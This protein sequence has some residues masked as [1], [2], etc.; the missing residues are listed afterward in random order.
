MG[1]R[2]LL[3][4]KNPETS[5]AM[6]AVC[7]IAGLPVEVCTDIFT[8]IEKGKTRAFSCVI[9]DWADQPEASFLLK[10]ARESASNRN[11]VAIAIVDNEPTAVEMRDHRLDF[12]IYRPISVEEAHAVLAKAGEQM[13]P[14]SGR[15]AAEPSGNQA[16]GDSSS[17]SVDGETA[18]NVPE[19]TAVPSLERNSEEVVGDTASER[20]EDEHQ[21][22]GHEERNLA[23]GMRGACAAGLLLTAAFC[24]W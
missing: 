10:R 8:A 11:T 7:E 16:G 24:L 20:H 1:F 22:R 13:R 5:P 17:G 23:I 14:L 2:A 6:T 18:A 4:S 21:A 9:T 3:F 15:D 19:D 12:L